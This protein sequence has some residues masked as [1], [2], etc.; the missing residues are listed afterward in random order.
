MT[1]RA[2]ALG[3]VL[4]AIGGAR[5]IADPGAPVRVV[6]VE[7]FGGAHGDGYSTVDTSGVAF[8][9]LHASVEARLAGRFSAQL[10]AMAGAFASGAPAYAV[11]ARG[12]YRD[13]RFLLGASLG[14]TAI[15]D[16]RSGQT[17]MLFAERYED[18]ALLVSAA[19]GYERKAAAPDLFVGELM[20]HMYPSSSTMLLAGFSYA[21]AEIKQTR[22][23]I[24][25][26]VEYAPFHVS[27]TTI[28][29]YAQFGGNLFTRASLGVV[30]YVDQLSFAMRERTRGVHA[31]RFK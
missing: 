15:V 28:A 2:C 27:G 1:W 18:R 3:I 16:E 19:I 11:A 9:G 8:G 31:L 26:R 24:V 21:H 6:R 17:A 30:L 13:A 12:Y 20:L 23:D 7:L 10:D 22:A 4:T 29:G 25:M 5:A 14:Q